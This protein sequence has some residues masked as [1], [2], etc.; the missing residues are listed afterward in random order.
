MAPFDLLGMVSYSCAVVTLSVEIFDFK[1]DVNLKTVC[2]KNHIT[3]Y[4][5]VSFVM[6]LL[7]KHVRLACGFNKLM[8][9]MKIA[10]FSHPR[11]FNALAEGV[12]LGIG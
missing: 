8:I 4:L 9:M 3:L 11:V 10:N 2:R 7:C 6:F 12:P 1:N 5:C